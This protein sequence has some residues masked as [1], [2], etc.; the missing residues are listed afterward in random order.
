MLYRG[1]QRLTVTAHPRFKVNS[2]DRLV[3]VKTLPSTEWRKTTV[4][5]R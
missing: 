1:C 5:N 3:G 4:I 2:A